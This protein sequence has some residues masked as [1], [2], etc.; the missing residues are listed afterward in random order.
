MLFVREGYGTRL[1]HLAEEVAP[2]VEAALSQ[3]DNVVT[4]QQASDAPRQGTC[5]SSLRT[6]MSSIV[7]MP[8]LITRL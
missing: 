6:D 8:A 1:M 2:A 4:H 7:L 5:F 3:L